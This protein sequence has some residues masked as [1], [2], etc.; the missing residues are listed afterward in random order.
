MEFD[1][2]SESLQKVS[3]KVKE[4]VVGNDEV[5]EL[6]VVAFF[7][8]GHVLLEGVPG[9]G[10]TTIARTFAQSVGGEF[11]RVQMTPDLLPADVI[12]TEIYRQRKSEFEVRK[13]PIFANFVL[14][15]E[16]NRGTPKVQSAFLEAMQERQ[17][18]IGGD[19]YS[20]DRP[21]IVVATQSPFE[22]GTYP[23][24][25]VQRD[26]FAYKVPVDYPEREEE[27][28]IIGEIDRIDDIEV[29]AILDPQESSE[30][31]EE[32]RSVTVDQKVQN[33]IVDLN[34]HLRNREEVQTG[35][36]P[37]ASIWLYKG[38]RVRAVLRGRDYV[39]PDDVKGLAPYAMPHRISVTTEAEAREVSPQKLVQDALEEVSVP[40]GLER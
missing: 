18:T 4:V 14:A 17:V 31:I 33:Y 2:V 16:F 27:V 29:D 26:R 21:F 39:I 11:K 5:V 7:S 20:L 23:L 30:V 32:F 8:E 19:T 25:P 40:K 12:G 37:R 36:S 38:S 28:E 9:I 24:T 6:L 34:T 35:P 22:H 13:G 3:S 1:S 15:D 10:K